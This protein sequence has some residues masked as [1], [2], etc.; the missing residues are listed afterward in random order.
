MI[1]NLAQNQE[2]VKD[3]IYTEESCHEI[4]HVYFNKISVHHFGDTS[5]AVIQVMVIAFGSKIYTTT[6]TN[7]FYMEGNSLTSNLTCTFK[8][9]SL[10]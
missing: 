1:L 5:A 3:P 10:L 8:F 7:K 4:V 9:L 2:I 6:V